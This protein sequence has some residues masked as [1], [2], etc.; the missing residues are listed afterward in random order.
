MLRPVVPLI[1][2]AACTSGSEERTATRKSSEAPAAAPAGRAART[3]PAAPVEPG[4]VMPAFERQAIALA[5]DGSPSSVAVSSRKTERPTVYLFLGT[6][7]RTTG[8]YLGRIA[9]LEKQYAG[10][11]DFVY[12]YPNKTDSSDEKQAFHK[13]HQL[14]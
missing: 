8:N 10:K 4:Q 6:R 5:A 13:K 11:V 3:A 9:S 1:L 12:L 7:C 2:L 14:R